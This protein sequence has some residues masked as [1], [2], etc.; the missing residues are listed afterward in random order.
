VSCNNTPFRTTEGPGNPDPANFPEMMGIETKMTNRALR[1]LELYGQDPSITR[2]EF[3]AYKFDKTYSQD[4]AMAVFLD[5][6]FKSPDN[7]DPL[8]KEAIDLLKKWDRKTDKDNTGAAL[9]VFAGEPYRE[10][11]GSSRE[12]PEPDPV[13]LTLAAAKSLKA[14]HGRLDI[15]WKDMMRLRHGALDLPLG[16][17]PDCLRA[18]DIS[19]LQDDGRF[20]GVNG[21]CYFLMVQWDKDGKLTSEGIHQYGAATVDRN[22][23]HYNDQAP[24]FAEEKMRPTLL[25]EQDIRAHLEKEYRPGD[26]AEPWYK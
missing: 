12:K 25:A 26:V 19:A 4:S 13:A 23:P 3:Y 21:D 10:W 2:E 18:I 14:N 9:A 24:L 11:Y 15:P 7:G 5:K 6:L 16:G 22:S 17:G 1:A 8:L 20:K